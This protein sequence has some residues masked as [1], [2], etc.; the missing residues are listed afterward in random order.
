L[1]DDGKYDD[2]TTYDI[3]YVPNAKIPVH[4]IEGLE[5]GLKELFED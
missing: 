5:I 3:I 2:G 1:Q 4:T